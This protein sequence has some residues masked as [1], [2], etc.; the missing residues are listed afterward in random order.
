ML[1][2]NKT[3]AEQQIEINPFDFGTT[4]FDIIVGNPPYMAT[5]HMK[6][7][8]PLELPPYKE[9]YTHSAYKQFDKYFLFIERGLQLL[10]PDGYFG[11]IVPSNRAKSYFFR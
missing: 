3:P 8:T 2:S 4:K 10:K 6:E 11:Y 5:E 9:H 1:D 7:F